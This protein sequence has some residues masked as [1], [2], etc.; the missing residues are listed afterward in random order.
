MKKK[1]ARFYC[2]PCDNAWID[3]VE[4]DK[5]HSNCEYCSKL[6]DAEFLD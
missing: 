4:S 6:C 1:L 3:I 2:Q 5:F